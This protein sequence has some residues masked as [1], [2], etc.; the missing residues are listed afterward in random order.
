MSTSTYISVKNP[1]PG[2]RSYSES[3]SPIFF[4]RERQLDELL[5]KIRANRFLAVTGARSSGKSSLVRASLIPRLNSREGFSGQGGDRW[6]I[7]FCRPGNDPIENLSK[8][9]AKEGILYPENKMLDTGFPSVIKNFLQRGSLGL[10]EAYQK[11]KQGNSSNLMIVIDQFEEIFR[12]ARQSKEHRDKAEL[13]VSLLLNASRHKA[14][15]IYV[16]VLMRS[17]YTDHNTM[18]RGLSEAFNEGRFEIPPMKTQDLKRVI[19]APIIS[20]DAHKFTGASSGNLEKGLESRIINDLDPED[21]SQLSV[22]QHT[23]TKMWDD[24]YE[25]DGFGNADAPVTLQHYNAVGGVRNSI[26]QQLEAIYKSIEKQQGQRPKDLTPYPVICKK[27]FQALAEPG[28]TGRSVSRPVS[29]RTLMAITVSNLDDVKNI[30]YKFSEPNSLFLEAPTKS[31]MD[32]DTIIS[33]RHEC[34]FDKWPLLNQWIVEEEE[35]AKLYI[36]MA[37]AATIYHETKNPMKL[38]GDPELK[39]GLTWRTNEM[40]NEAWA[41]RYNDPSAASFD[42]TIEFL[43]KSEKEFYRQQNEAAQEQDARIKRSRNIGIFGVIIAVF[44]SVLTLIAILSGQEAYKSAQKAKRSER[45]AKQKSYLAQL[46]RQDANNKEFIATL[47]SE[48]AEREQL[49]ATAAASDAVVATGIANDQMARALAAL[50][51][52]DINEQL[53]LQKAKEADSAKVVAIAAGEL[54]EEKRKIAVKAVREQRQIRNRSLAQEIAVKSQEIE[55]ES[56][57]ALLAKEAYN[58]HMGS[59]GKPYNAFIYK[60]LYNAVDKLVPR[61][62]YLNYKVLPEGYKRIGTVRAM[63]FKNGKL[64]TT[65]SEGFLLEWPA[66]ITNNYIANQPDRKNYAPVSVTDPDNKVYRALD[67]S[68]NGDWLARGGDNGKVELYGLT[69]SGIPAQTAPKVQAS[70]HKGRTIWTLKFMPDSKGYVSSGADGSIQYTNLTGESVEVVA[71]IPSEL[72]RITSLDLSTD[73]RFLAA[74]GLSPA[75]YIWDQKTGKT[76][77]KLVTKQDESER[78][79]ARAVAIGGK[80]DRFVAVGFGDGSVRIWDLKEPDP[81][82]RSKLKEPDRLKFHVASIT[83]LEF[84]QS[85]NGL[86]LAAGSR[87]NSTTLWQVQDRDNP[88]IFPYKTNSFSPIK[89][90][91]KNHKSWVM[92]VAFSEDGSHLFT[93]Y[94]DGGIRFWETTM[95]FYSDH[96]CSSLN[97]NLSDDTWLKYIGSDGTD[98]AYPYILTAEGEGQERRPMW[99]CKGGKQMK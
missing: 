99:T 4:G 61:F 41:Q 88:T 71:N 95:D 96:I 17:S 60:S 11:H 90:E 49:K 75:V 92:S 3:E 2:L 23:L 67:I 98:K 76:I 56:I 68:A 38:W 81:Y 6:R 7:A 13:F 62:N 54:A 78:R 30:V 59:E 57:K 37:A 77:K 32:E 89:L 94:Q 8:N 31:E 12:Y 28:P 83:C 51:R 26:R 45:L 85:S 16:V 97:L 15:P 86:M 80:D 65:G 39:M 79:I 87:D 47:N 93:G 73:G 44:C 25:T 72:K 10:V 20:S 9:L 34:I 52:A 46:A 1:Y 35:N 14:S 42:D 43:D 66:E 74:V 64:Y 29:I 33:V 70:P 48:R 55:D 19:M 36:R 18:F 27:I 84:N 21:L 63:A 40:P 69:S 91:N 24:W 82:D 5:R 58:I 53:A 50:K 22:I